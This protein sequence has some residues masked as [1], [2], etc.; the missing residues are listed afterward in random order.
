MA[1]IDSG[2]M[3]NT[4]HGVCAVT[5]FILFIINLVLTNGAYKKLMKIDPSVCSKKSMKWK[6]F[7]T[8][9]IIIVA[10]VEIIRLLIGYFVPLTG[11]AKEICIIEWV[12]VF[13]FCFYFYSFSWDWKGYTYNLSMGLSEMKDNIVVPLN[14]QN[15][16]SQV[17]IPTVYHSTP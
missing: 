10:I 6:V 17:E 16:F 12:T 5:F 7:W 9:V 1:T 14:S 13:G 8:W 15:Y 4:L 11:T 3:D 2:K